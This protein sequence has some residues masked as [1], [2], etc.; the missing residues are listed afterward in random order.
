MKRMT[1]IAALSSMI[2]LPGTSHLQAQPLPSR[3]RLVLQ[4]GGNLTLPTGEF[5]STEPFFGGFATSSVGFQARG[6]YALSRR[7]SLF[8]GVVKPRFGYDSTIIEDTWGRDIGDATQMFSIV[9]TG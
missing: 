9:N 6:C 1:A 5:S 4:A 3:P 8:A 2:L 7:F